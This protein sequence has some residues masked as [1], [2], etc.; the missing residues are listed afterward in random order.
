MGN[1]ALKDRLI[2]EIGEMPADKVQEVLNFVN[3]LNLKEDRWFIDLV[4]GRT[5]LAA[6]DKSAGKRF[7][8]LGELQ[9]EYK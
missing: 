5:G 8:S 1:T 6:S 3:H 2:K 9:K 7:T 4:N